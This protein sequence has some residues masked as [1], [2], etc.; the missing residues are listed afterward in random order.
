[1]AEKHKVCR[2]EE[3][4]PGRGR[5]FCVNGTKIALFNVDGK[6]YATESECTHEGTPL[7]EGPLRG[8]RVLCP[9]HGAEFD[10]TTGEALSAPASYP[11]DCYRVSVEAGE[12]LVEL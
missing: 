10:V 2:V 3:L 5:T 4:P 1:M 9:S 6:F 11:V 7:A 8:S 12:V